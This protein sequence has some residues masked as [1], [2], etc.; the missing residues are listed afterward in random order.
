MN[1]VNEII[2]ESRIIA[3][4]RV[5]F[6]AGFNIFLRNNGPLLESTNT[7]ILIHKSI[8]NMPIVEYPQNF[9]YLKDCNLVEFYGSE[10]YQDLAMDTLHL[11]IANCTKQ[12]FTLISNSYFLCK[13]ADSINDFLSAAVLGINS[14]MIDFDGKIRNY[15]ILDYNYFVNM[16]KGEDLDD[17]QL[18]GANENA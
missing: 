2:K 9:A 15:Q 1:T 7:K 11:L 17:Y 13:N 3:D 18:V 16:M 10:Y 8:D 5:V 6:D 12:R 14:K 4:A